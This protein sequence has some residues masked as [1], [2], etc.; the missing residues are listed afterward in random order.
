MRAL[1]ELIDSVPED[2]ASDIMEEIREVIKKKKD[3]IQKIVKGSNLSCR[4]LSIIFGLSKSTIANI[5]KTIIINKVALN[6]KEKFIKEIFEKYHR[7]VGRQPITIHLRRKYNI[8]LS[9][10]QVGRIMN[11]LGLKCIVRRKK[12]SKEPKNTNVYL[13][14]IVNRDYKNNKHTNEIL[15]TDVT[16]I[17]APNDVSGNFV[18]LSVIISHRT[19]SVISYKLSRFN[20]S[21]L[22][23]NTFNNLNLNNKII[24]SDHG[25]TYCSFDFFKMINSQNCFQSM[26]RIG[27][28]LDNREVEHLFC[29]L[30]NE[31]IHHLDFKRINFNELQKIIDNYFDHY[32]N[33]RIQKNLGWL[34]PNEYK[35]TLNLESVQI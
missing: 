27:N 23:F 24:H 30:K 35:K 19:K 1:K 16:Y 20:D 21:Q 31:L 12:R 22:I 10:R 18:Y 3:K 25:S 2:V 33:I 26:S 32:N 8:F 14:N 7:R 17:P 29:I 4:K 11:K 28:S 9:E 5:R 15:A 13:P 6:D 34:S